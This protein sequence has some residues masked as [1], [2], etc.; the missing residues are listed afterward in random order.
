[1]A[2]RVE[3]VKSVFHSMMVYT[4]MIYKWPK[5]LLHK[6]DMHAKNFICNGDSLVRS[7]VTV[8]WRKMSKPKIEGGLGI[9]SLVEFNDA[10]MKKLAWEFVKAKKQW[11]VFMRARFLAKGRPIQYYK[12]SSTWKGIK[13]A[14]EIISLDITWLIG[15]NSKLLL[16]HDNWTGVGPLSAIAA[17]PN[18]LLNTQDSKVGD[19][20]VDGVLHIPTEIMHIVRTAGGDLS[21]VVVPT[22]E[23][24]DEPVWE[25]ADN[26]ILTVKGAYEYYREKETER[27]WLEKLW[28]RFLPPKISV[29]LWRIIHDRLPTQWNRLKCGVET[30]GLC[31]LC[32]DQRILEDQ[33]H[34][35][36]HCQYA[37]TVWSWVE[38]FLEVNFLNFRGIKQ[39][40]LHCCKW[41]LK[42][43]RN[44]LRFAL[45][46]CAIWE[47]WKSRN[48]MIFNGTRRSARECIL[49]TRRLVTRLG[50]L[51]TGK[52]RNG[53]GMELFR[54]FGIT[55][56]VKHGIQVKEVRW[57]PPPIGWHKANFDGAARGSPGISTCGGIFRNHRGFVRG[58]FAIPLGVQS[59]LFAEMC[60]FMTV[61]EIAAQKQWFPIWLE[62]DSSILVEKVKKKDP[63]VPW[64]IR[65]RW[66]NCLHVLENNQYFITHIYREGNKVA[67]AVANIAFSLDD[68][69]WWY[70]VP[71]EAYDFY[72]RNI[73]GSVEFRIHY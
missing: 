24:Q 45:V 65:T 38:G 32:E 43:Q 50:F 27:P 61:V 10:A 73:N 64:Q 12:G 57:V 21:H 59:A 25:G 1:M 9:R 5:N 19:Y 58:C 35:I 41:D 18:A 46:M 62:S 54:A 4:M 44:Q 48:D 60:A 31:V 39:V 23:C 34:F 28:Q 51:M 47:I 66:Y 30:D 67:D 14:L 37:A 26:G 36:L 20:V 33:D 56:N 29:M 6:L 17:I 22:V 16:W 63:E 13:E 49:S 7:V 11:A 15:S 68:F 42:N 53:Q 72:C 55:M 69:T 71:E 40:L 52:V 70:G 8:Q 2:G 3:L